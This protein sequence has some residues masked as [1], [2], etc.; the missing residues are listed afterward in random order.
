MLGR[1]VRYGADA[2]M[3]STVLAGVKHASGLSPDL[4][5]ISEPNVR[6]FIRQYLNLGDY[7]FNSGV[8]FAQSSDYFRAT[9]S[10]NRVPML[11]DDAPHLRQFQ[12]ATDGRW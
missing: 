3:I 11:G 4:E 2:V 6:G 10:Q 12:R 5:R 7:V 9:G 1:L 8:A